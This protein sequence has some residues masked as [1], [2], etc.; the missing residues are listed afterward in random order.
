[1]WSFQQSTGM[2]AH[3]GGEVGA[4]YSGHGSG[5]NNPAWQREPMVGPI[6]QGKYRIG[7]PFAHP[8]AGPICMRLT[9]LPGTNTFGRAGFMMHGDNRAMDHTASEG[10]IIAAR[11]YRLQV[12][13]TVLGGD[14]VLEVIA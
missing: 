12:A 1:M 2:L 7:A 9:A 8:A 11:G 5:V 6:P 4:G 3:D 13:A 10:C 14:D